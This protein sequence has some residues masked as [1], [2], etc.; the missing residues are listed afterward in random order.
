MGMEEQ[1]RF[2]CRGC[3]YKFSRKTSWDEDICPYCGKAAIEKEDT[4]N[5]MINDQL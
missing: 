4:L 3:R 2:I 5:R 1:I